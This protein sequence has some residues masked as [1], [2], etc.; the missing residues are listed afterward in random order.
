[1]SSEAA[2][3]I[4]VSGSDGPPPLADMAPEDIVG[5]YRSARLTY[6]DGTS[7]SVLLVDEEVP[8]PDGRLLL[9]STDVHGRIVLVNRS[10]VELSGYAREELIG[11]PI[12]I[13]QHPST[14]AAVLAGLWSR[15]RAGAQWRGCVKYLRKDGRYFWAHEI[16]IANVRNGRTVAYTSVRRKASRG[17]IARCERDRI[18]RAFVVGTGTHVP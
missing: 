14:P 17:E 9:S 3:A 5:R 11:A 7:R 6:A 15:V 10:L 12:Q 18:S 13:L 4:R 2:A 16:V 1:M 8:F